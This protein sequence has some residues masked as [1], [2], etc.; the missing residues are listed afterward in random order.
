MRLVAG[1]C[2]E[3]RCSLADI[4][5]TMN[6]ARFSFTNGSVSIARALNKITTTKWLVKS[7]K[8]TED[9]LGVHVINLGRS[10]GDFVRMVLT[11]SCISDE[12]C[13]GNG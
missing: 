5:S 3:S 12:K 13:S 11:R 10:S 1:F 6:S 9:L 7:V 4:N 8:L 2:G